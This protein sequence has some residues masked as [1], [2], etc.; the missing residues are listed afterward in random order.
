MDATSPSPLENRK[1]GAAVRTP[2]PSNIIIDNAPPVHV[3]KKSYSISSIQS[4]KRSLTGSLDLKAIATPLA[5]CIEGEYA[6]DAA[7]LTSSCKQCYCYC[8]YCLLFFTKQTIINLLSFPSVKHFTR[9]IWFKPMG[10]D[11]DDN[12]QDDKFQEELYGWFFKH[13]PDC[14]GIEGDSSTIYSKVGEVLASATKKNINAFIEAAYVFIKTEGITHFVHQI[15]L[16]AAKYI[17]TSTSSKSSSKKGGAAIS[18]P[19]TG[20]AGAG[21]ESSDSS[22]TIESSEQ[23]IGKIGRNG[24]VV[25]APGDKRSE[26]VIGYSLLPISY[27]IQDDK[28][29]TVVQEAV[30]KYIAKAS[31]MQDFDFM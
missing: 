27:L 29:K 2:M 21:A 5:I 3:E 19:G 14:N 4:L 6:R 1:R 28:M 12:W 31:K 22:T 10:V 18:V 7:E 24:E 8:D 30:L 23:T 17:L 26:G 11:T 15:D 20:S 16:G 13:I 25:V 9:S